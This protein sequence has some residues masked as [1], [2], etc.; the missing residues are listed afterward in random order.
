MKLPKPSLLFI[1]YLGKHQY[2]DKKMEGLAFMNNPLPNLFKLNFKLWRK[3]EEVSNEPQKMGF[4]HGWRWVGQQLFVQ[5]HDKTGVA[6]KQEVDGELLQKVSNVVIS[7]D[8]VHQSLDL[9]K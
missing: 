4:V 9:V 2:L 1:N 6:L 3:F 5:A 8:V 7:G